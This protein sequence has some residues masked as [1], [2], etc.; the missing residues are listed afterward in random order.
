[1]SF[2]H[3]YLL[4]TLLVLPAAVGLYLL[5]QRRAMR[6]AVRYTNLDVLASVAG[7]RE[8]RRW[9]PPA[10]FLLALAALCVGFARPHVTSLVPR[11][12]ATVILVVDVSRSMQANDVKPTR[13][14]AAQAGVRTFLEHAPKNL[15][16]ALI[17]FAGE[18]QVASPPTYDHDL[19]RQAVDDLGLY[20]GFGGTAIGDALAAA[21]LLAKQAVSDDRSLASVSAA[22][23]ARGGPVSILFLSD[24]FQ[25]RG[26]LL[27]L[28][29]AQRAKTAGIPVFTIA[30]G[31]P[32]GTLDRGFGGY[33]Y[34]NG[35]VPVPPDPATLSAIART[36][37]GQFFAA[38]SANALQSAYAKLGAR[39]TRIPRKHEV[40]YEFV[41]IAAGLLLGAGLL[42]AAWSPRLP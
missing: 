19:V 21:V 29:G 25:T 10:L 11:N 6:Y 16:V 35:R 30:L 1:V 24:G 13:L 28:Q 27:P 15:R 5:G 9:V 2:G 14:G 36:T 20:S 37:G 7:R 26:E 23:P 12:R 4:L 18:A 34:G 31:T 32:N 39:L 33:G 22:P 17:A 40:T 8:W 41:A 3:P 42:S 38:R